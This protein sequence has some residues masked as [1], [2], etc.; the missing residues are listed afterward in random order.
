MR[1]HQR[2]HGLCHPAAGKPYYQLPV[3][4]G[5]E[6]E[7]PVELTRMVRAVV[8]YSGMDFRA[9]LALP[10]EEVFVLLG[11]IKDLH[12][13]RYEYES[14]ITDDM[15]ETYLKTVMASVVSSTM[16]TPREITRDLI[17][18]LDTMHQNPDLEFLDLV[19]GRVINAD[20][21]P[22]DEIIEDL[23]V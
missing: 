16:L 4:P 8:E 15:L 14:G 20:S 18:L 3:K 22:D 11:T 10:N 13:Q 17:S 9:A 23:D 12:E 2:V 6:D 1:D 7:G 5:D 19:E 21:N